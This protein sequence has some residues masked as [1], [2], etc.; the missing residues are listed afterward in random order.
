[1]SNK[2]TVKG[3]N[4]GELKVVNGEE[5]IPS[6]PRTLNEVWGYDPIK[7]YGT[8][9]LEAYKAMLA[10]LNLADLQDHAI[11]KGI[12]PADSRERTTKRLLSAFDEYRSKHIKVEAKQVNE[13]SEKRRRAIEEIMRASK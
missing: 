1:M 5:V 8:L 3:K 7:E 10:K 11:Q 4:L 12:L 2:K 9:D 13:L 6:K